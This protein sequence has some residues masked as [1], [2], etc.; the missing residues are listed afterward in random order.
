MTSPYAQQ[1]PPYS[2]MQPIATA[3]VPGAFPMPQPDIPMMPQGGWSPLNTTCPPGLEYLMALDHL[4][5]QQKIE[6]IEALIGFETKNKYSVVNIRGEPVFYVVEES[7]ICSRMC[8][9]ASRSCEFQVYDGTRREV[10]RMIRPFRCDSCC[11]PCCLQELEVFSG[12]MF[13]GSVVQDWSLWQPTFSIRNASGET[14][15]IIEGPWCK[16]CGDVKFKVLSVNGENRVGMIKKEWSGLMQ[17]FFTDVDNFGISFP[18]DLDVKIK[19]VLL[20]AC[21]L[22]DFMYF[23]HSGHNNV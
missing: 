19:A 21:L 6:L 14:V 12:N 2:P 15:L 18:L 22:I 17:E 5:V 11:C 1:P 7:N 16:F 20:G 3:P 4:F 23:E 10:L 13:L 9:G 8:L